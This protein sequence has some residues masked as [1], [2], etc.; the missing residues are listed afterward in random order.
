[1]AQNHRMHLPKEKPMS[2]EDDLVSCDIYYLSKLHLGSNDMSRTVLAG[3]QA[4]LHCDILT[5]E[6]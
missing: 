4:L 3:T 1:M 5:V 6:L 2:N